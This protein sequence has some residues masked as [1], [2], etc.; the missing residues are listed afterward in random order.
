[1]RRIGYLGLC[2]IVSITLAMGLGCDSSSSGGG[3]QA[4]TGY[5]Q[6]DLAGEW[7]M[8]GSYFGRYFLKFDDQGKLLRMK[9]MWE[10]LYP[11]IGGITV[12]PD[13]RLRGK[14]CFAWFFGIFKDCFSFN[15]LR[16]KTKDWIS[17]KLVYFTYDFGGPK[18]FYWAGPVKMHPYPRK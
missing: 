9:G 11:W 1:M 2:L 18:D 10:K 6:A 12:L 4:A 16:F 13:G 17:G 15:G 7:G 3:G 8:S 14:V 5:T